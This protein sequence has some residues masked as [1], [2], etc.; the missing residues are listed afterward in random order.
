[1][2]IYCF[3]YDQSLLNFAF[4]LVTLFGLLFLLSKVAKR[5]F[6]RKWALALFLILYFAFRIA[7]V[8]VINSHTNKLFVQSEIHSVVID[9]IEWRSG[10]YRCKL[11]NGIMYFASSNANTLDQIGDSIVKKANTDSFYVYRKDT[12]IGIYQLVSRR[13]Y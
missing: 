7:I 6:D 2:D 10:A 3:V 11:G 13:K 12:Q 5:L 4:T 8:Q 9:Q 1:M